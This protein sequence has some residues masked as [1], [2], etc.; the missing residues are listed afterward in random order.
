MEMEHILNT[1]PITF[2]FCKVEGYADNS[3]D[4]VYKDAP[5]HVQHNI[6]MDARAKSLLKTIKNNPQPKDVH[7]F[8]A[9]RI[10][11]LLSDLPIVGNILYQIQQH[12]YGHHLEQQIQASLPQSPHNLHSIKWRGI[13]MAFNNLPTTD[14]IS[15]M[16]IVHQLLPTKSLLC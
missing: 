14:Q 12:C 15:C 11:L 10:T 4:F 5:Q 6:D 9:Q 7:A 16:K 13:E 8:L 1:S 3:A 2:V